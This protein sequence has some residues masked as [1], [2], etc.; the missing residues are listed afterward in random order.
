MIYE[1]GSAV[2]H[3]YLDIFFL[4]CFAKPIFRATV[5]VETEE[6]FIVT[7]ILSKNFP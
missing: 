1:D 2:Y 3:S 5:S 6:H 7:I 4:S